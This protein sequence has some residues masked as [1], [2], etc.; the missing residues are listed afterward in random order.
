MRLKSL[1]IAS[2]LLLFATLAAAQSKPAG[3]IAGTW[4]GDMG[5][6]ETERHAITITLKHDGTTIT[7]LITGPPYPGD[8]KGGS[9]DPKTGA[10]RLDVVVR[11]DNKTQVVF[12]GK[13][14]K[15]TV[16]GKVT[17]TA[18]SGREGT[19]RLKRGPKATPVRAPEEI[20]AAFEKHKG[21]FDYLLGDWEF[22]ATSK[23]Y[24]KFRGYW[25]AV[26]LDEG[27]ILDEYR[28]VGDKGETHYVTTT[29]RNYNKFADRWEL[30]G[31][32]GGGGLQDY[33]TGH[34]A[35]NEVRIEQK[36]GVASGSASTWRIR[37]YN[38]KP[39][40][41][42]WSA[43]RSIDEGKTWVKDFQAIEARRIGPPRTLG[44]LAPARKGS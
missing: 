24:D 35:G 31:A 4:T 3:E 18:D 17:F 43:D 40:S 29:I 26:K 21:D 9:F 15:D 32:D 30:T 27:Q 19:F 12:Q 1:P 37:Y 44:P 13:L 39:D 23:E 8:I 38:I 28:I 41:F 20:E 10:L 42:S 7:G 14:V 6:S 33:G 16:A 25:S 22:T 5:P 11:D 34:R 36:F 2:V